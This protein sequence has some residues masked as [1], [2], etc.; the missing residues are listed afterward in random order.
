MPTSASGF[1]LLIVALAIVLTAAC[2]SDLPDPENELPAGFL[3]SPSA[4]M[5]VPRQF[6]FAGWALDNSRAVRVDVYVDGRF[7]G[8]TTPS[9]KRPDVLK[10]FPQYARNSDVC[11]WE[12]TIDLGEAP[13]ARFVLAQAVDDAGAT[14][15]LG[16]A[17][18]S[19]AK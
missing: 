17:A 6:R 2:G 19:V 16:S 10:A 18:I 4:G 11:G 7:R 8:S 5:V 14:R 12:L 13:G 15:D 9:V 1:R 3:D